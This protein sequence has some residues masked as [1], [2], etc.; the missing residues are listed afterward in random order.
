MCGIFGTIGFPVDERKVFSSLKHRG[1]DQQG[2]FTHGSISL[3]HLRLSIVDL[4]SG[5][6]PMTLGKYTIVYNGEF[7]NHKEIREKYR[8]NC[9]TD[10]DTETLLRF[11]SERGWSCFDEIDGMFA[12]AI[13]DREAN[14]VLLARDRSGKKPLYVYNDMSVLIFSSELNALRSVHELSVDRSNINSYLAGCLFGRRTP[15]NKVEELGPGSICRIECSTLESKTERW[16]SIDQYYYKNKINSLSEC[17]ELVD[18]ELVKAVE[19]R[20]LQSDLEVGTFLSGGIDSGIVTSIAASIAPRIKSFTV[21]LDGEYDESFLAK[22]VADKYNTDHHEIDISFDNLQQDFEKIVLSYGEPFSDSSAI[23]SYYVA[24]EAKKHV[25]VVL[26]GDGADELF[27][28]YRRYVP[29]FKMDLYSTPEYL[30]KLARLFR[31]YLPMPG[32]KKSKYNYIYRLINLLAANGQDLY[33]Y[34]TTDVFTGYE[35]CFIDVENV[36]KFDELDELV[37]RHSSLSALEKA[38]ILDFNVLMQG[39]LLVKMDIATMQHSLEARSPFLAKGVVELAPRIANH[40]KIR[41]GATKAV[42]REL[43]KRYVPSDIVTQPKRGFEIPLLEWI[44]SDRYLKPL[45]YGHLDSKDSFCSEFVSYEFIVEL[46]HK[47]DRFP[48]EK[49]AKM[50][51]RLMVLEIWSKKIA[52]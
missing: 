33:W 36:T 7:Y 30:S 19:S 38:M 26:N 6:Q 10:S 46:M 37:K 13:Y 52:A 11:Y 49:R 44:N 2:M 14:T 12:L 16:W 24:Q 39:V 18:A 50:L 48:A 1:P 21:R 17:V 29:F 15:Y 23:P 25:S 31:R 34:A 4:S 20:L 41:R 40:N 42:L 22:L 45:V 8:I 9:D 51:Y 3:Y 5:T 32:V 47:P 43:S 28:G 35:E 27:G